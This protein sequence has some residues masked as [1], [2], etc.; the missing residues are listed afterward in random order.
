MNKNRRSLPLWLT[1]EE[2]AK[3]LKVNY[4][5]VYDNIDLLPHMRIGR[6]IRIDRDGLFMKARNMAHLQSSECPAY[7][8]LSEMLN[9]LHSKEVV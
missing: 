2:A 6:A 3:V 4:Q 5:T 7:K 8:E 1:V 9:E